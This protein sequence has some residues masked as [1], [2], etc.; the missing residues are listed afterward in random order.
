MIAAHWPSLP[1]EPVSRSPSLLALPC[2]APVV[3]SP[4]EIAAGESD[5]QSKSTERKSSKVASAGE[6]CGNAL[7]SDPGCHSRGEDSTA[8]SKERQGR[9]EVSEVGEQRRWRAG[10]DHA[11]RGARRR[12]PAVFAELA[13]W[14]VPLSQPLLPAPGPQSSRRPRRL[15]AASTAVVA[16]VAMTTATTTRTTRS[17]RMRKAQAAILQVIKCCARKQFGGW[18]KT[19]PWRV[20]VGE[21]QH[22]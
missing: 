11:G 18:G 5:I 16:V 6:G 19:L 1:Q 9:T 20:A 13:A 2:A 3:R 15:G 14:R 4:P 7:P 22:R 21:V 17:T 10:G 8:E 12:S